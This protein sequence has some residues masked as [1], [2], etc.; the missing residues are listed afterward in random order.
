MLNDRL[1]ELSQKPDPPFIGAGGGEGRFVREAEVFSLGA[2]V[3]DTGI[4]RGFHAVLTEVERVD[5]HGFTASELDRARRDVLRSYE[6]AY[7]EREK[8]ESGS[9]VEEYVQNF[10]AHEPTPGIAYEYDLVK[11]LLP[12]I[13]L[14]E[15]NGAAKSWFNLKDRVL[16]VS[17]PDKPSVTVPSSR[18]LLDLVDRVRESQV[19]AYE[20]N[21]SDAP[22]V[23]AALA[24]APIAT[25]TRDSALGLTTWTLA[26]GVRVIAKPTDFKA[27][28]VLLNAFSPGGTSVEPDSLFL[29]TRFAS[30]LVTLGGVGDFSA[31]DLQKKLAGK[32]VRVSPYI[33]SYEE[34]FQGSAS[35]KDLETLFQLIYLYATAPREDAGAFQAFQSNVRALLANRGAS[36]QVAF[37]DTLTVTLTQHHPR[38]RPL[39]TTEID[40]LDLD[41][42]FRAYQDRFRDLSDFTFVVVGSFQLD[43]LKPLV[44]RYLGNL[45][46]THRIEQ[47]R[48]V[49]IA[50]PTG[51]VERT[52]RKGVEPKSQT[53]LV[54]TGPFADSRADRFV[55]DALADVLDIKL[56]EALREELGGTYGVSVQA[57]PTRIPN[58]RYSFAI[59]FGSAPDRA[60]ELVRA[61]FVQIDSLQQQGAGQKEL[62][63]IRETIIRSHE[64]NLRQNGYWLGQIVSAEQNGDP[65]ARRIDPTDLLPL[66]TRERL[67]AAAQRYLDRKNYVRV[68]LL[69]QSGPAS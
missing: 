9:Y 67:K 35:P 42:S 39:S 31:I 60:D 62:D 24:P 7:A 51:V 14:R 45:P 50:P 47:W 40:S 33:G 69:P 63:K 34:G 38:T 2:A 18:E 65:L 68:T 64:T 21:L 8:S 52:V 13:G 43:S 23:A 44:R 37:Q 22:L 56:R 32:T 28:E 10:L 41:R 26:N 17:A 15:V 5:Q 59:G 49:G 27:D 46:A 61:V 54:F 48:D 1:Y 6:D 20:E 12:G 55:I 58:D 66:L 4:L 29:A 25:E 16:L 11:R 57:S 36:P 19:A 3:P 30:Q 53:Q